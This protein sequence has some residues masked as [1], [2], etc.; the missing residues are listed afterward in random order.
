GTHLRLRH[1]LAQRLRGNSQRPRR[2]GRV[3]VPRR[4]RADHEQ[5]L[6]D[7][8]GQHPDDRGAPLV[9]PARRARQ[10]ALPAALR[11]AAVARRGLHARIGLRRR[12]P[13]QQ[14]AAAAEALPHAGAGDGR[15]GP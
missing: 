11:R 15:A 3:R 12:L 9:P 4:S 5:G 10:A 1:H 7:G 2:R 14:P 13:G 8:G 6:P